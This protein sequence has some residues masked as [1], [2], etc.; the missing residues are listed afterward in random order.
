MQ[1][2]EI[3][4]PASPSGPTVPSLYALYKQHPILGRLTGRVPPLVCSL[5]HLYQHFQYA[6]KP[7]IETLLEMGGCPSRYPSLRTL[8]TRMLR[9]HKNKESSTPTLLISKFT[10]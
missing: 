3:L 5:L 2:A 10:C 9:P 8:L 7:D 1:P 4:L 6:R